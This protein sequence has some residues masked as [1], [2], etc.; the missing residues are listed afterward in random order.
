MALSAYA[1]GWFLL[2]AIP[3]GF[4]VAYSDLSRM[5]IPNVAVYALVASYAVLGLIVFPFDV[6]LWQWLHLPVILIIGIILNAAGAL[7][8]GDAK[9][10]AA[11]APYVM[12]ADLQPML[13]LFAACLLAGYATH[14]LAK[15]S[16]LRNMVPDWESWTAGKRFPM[17]YPLAMTLV[18]YIALA[19]RAT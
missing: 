18:F 2:A 5:K 7:G 14:R 19:M 6:Y 16:P 13:F 10:A 1:A 11:A 15:Y 12:L 3:I 8:A 17:G 9:F 4:Y